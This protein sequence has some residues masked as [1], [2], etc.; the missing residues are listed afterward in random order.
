MVRG[1]NPRQSRP[2]THETVGR[3]LSRNR[4][5]NGETQMANVVLV[6]GKVVESF[7][8]REAVMLVVE[9]ASGVSKAGKEWKELAACRFYGDSR[10][11]LESAGAE[12]GSYVEVQGSFTSRKGDKGY[13]SGFEARFIRVIDTGAG[14]DV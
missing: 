14:G 8:D 7:E 5:T 3:P 4:N 10:V 13:F 2:E 11:K 12:P 9:T 6:T 1:E